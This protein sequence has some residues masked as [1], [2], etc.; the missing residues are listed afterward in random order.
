MRS[1][2]VSATS[3]RLPAVDAQPA[4]A[5]GH[6]AHGLLAGR[7]QDPL[8]RG[9]RGGALQ[10]QRRLADARLAADQRHRPRDEPAAQ[11]AVE[12][13]EAGR[14]ARL[15]NRRELS[16]S[17]RPSAAR[18]RACRR[19]R[20]AP[21][22]ARACSTRRRTDTAR[23]SG[24]HRRRRTSRRTPCGAWPSGEFRAGKAA[25]LARSVAPA[26]YARTAAQVAVSAISF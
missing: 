7:V 2:A 9:E 26:A 18:R 22:T 13:R 25:M 11:H 20:A 19:A 4:R 21:R 5:L 17:L 1:T 14:P 12:F 8:A 16:D 15:G 3:L 24:A 10:E 23:S 6:L